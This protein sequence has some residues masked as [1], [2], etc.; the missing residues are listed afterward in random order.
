MRVIY[1]L[2][3]LLCPK[4]SAAQTALKTGDVVPDVKFT[5]LV[6]GL[7]NASSLHKF[8]S[9]LLLLDFW[10]TT[11]IPCVEE[12][13][14]WDSMQKAYPGDLA[15]LLVSSAKSDNEQRLSATMERIHKNKA[16]RVSLPVILGDTL[17]NKLFPHSYV[18]HYAWLDSSFKV[19]AITGDDEAT[20]GQ[21]EA[22]L[23]GKP[24]RFLGNQAREQ[25]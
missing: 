12:I 2:M 4:L 20:P 1:C 16:V 11:C 24:L 15:V 18:P 7:A 6:N 19:V 5:K 9:K 25:F 23:Q 14:V 8:K 17:L 21:V 22:W 13:P 3:I 10:M